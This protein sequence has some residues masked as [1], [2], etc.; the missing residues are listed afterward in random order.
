MIAAAASGP[1]ESGPAGSGPAESGPA[2]SGP[3]PRWGVR[4]IAGQA[5]RAPGMISR[6]RRAQHTIVTS[7]VGVPVK[8]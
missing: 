8:H 5:R 4:A 1:A 6:A 3:A 2:E 7:G